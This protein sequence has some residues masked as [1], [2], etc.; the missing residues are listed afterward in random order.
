MRSGP[1]IRSVKNW[2]SNCPDTTST[3]RPRTSVDTE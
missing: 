3:N 2:S 1:K